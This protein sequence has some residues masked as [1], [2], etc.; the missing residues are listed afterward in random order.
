MSRLLSRTATLLVVLATTFVFVSSYAQDASTVDTLHERLDAA[1]AR[2]ASVQD[3]ADT[4]EEQV[5]SI[6]RQIAAVEDALD[7]SEALVQRTQAEIGVLRVA[8]RDKE[9]RY[10]EV[11]GRAIDIAVSL[12]KA[13]PGGN[14]EP[15]LGAKTLDELNS[16]VE[17]SSAMSEDQISVMVSLKR[18][19]VELE[20]ESAELEIKLAEALE[21]RNEQRQQ[22]QHLRELRAAQRLK[23]AD[24]RKQI[25]SERAEADALV[26]ESAAIEAQLA[27]AAPVA[28]PA[29]AAV[30]DPAN[31][32]SGASGFAWPINGA[33]TSGYGYR[34]GRMHEGIDIDCVTG[35]PIRASKAGTVISST[36]DDGY[37]NHVVIDHGGG[38]ASL[39]AHM[40]ALHVT[41]G[42]VS[43]GESVGACGST[44]ASTGDHLHFEIRVNGS[45]Q[46]PLNYLP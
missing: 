9:E 13:G 26:E 40:S 30:P 20:A 33:V 38:L 1:R 3:Q 15:L 24:L 8:V 34:W 27:Q 35:A 19:Q 22:S 25:E 45:P 36:Y 29:V 12:Y 43:Q 46:D 31:L 11:K 21:V 10:E 23:L 32:S 42:S 18:L 17:Y 14:L 7:A 41:G 16:A 4:V 28:A 5:A 37:G 2:I 39:Y 44:G 6:D